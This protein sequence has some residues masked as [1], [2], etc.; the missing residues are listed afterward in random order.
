[1]R[2]KTVPSFFDR[3]DELRRQFEAQVGPSRN[4]EGTRFVWD[5]WHIPGQYTYLRTPA[6]GVVAPTLLAA[7]TEELRSWGKRNLGATRVT[8]PWLSYYIE[9]CRQELHTDVIQ[10]TWSY[11]Y[12]LT[13][14]DDR[15]FTGGETLLGDPR[16]L[17]YWDHFD[18]ERSSEARHLV[19]R[20]PARFDQLC[21][22]DSR[23]P[24][25]VG[26]VEGTRDPL[27]ARVAL[28]GWFHPAEPVSDGPL[29]LDD[30]EST[31]ADLQAQWAAE[32]TRVGPFYGESAWQLVVDQ[33]G[34][35]TDIDLLVDNLVPGR[36]GADPEELLAAAEAFI[37][38]S[39][40]PPSA[41]SSQVLLPLR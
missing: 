2:M 25:G 4:T 23:L 29:D 8:V 38:K 33:H 24:H 7:F 31:L 17:D 1:M 16:L 6:L 3:A 11:V 37:R 10:G 27:K 39:R 12:S 5:Y 21:V 28:H 20:V 40:F 22:F 15:E 30:A 34:R 35:V 13:S 19:E 32:N 41:G 18:P 36:R 9:G 26:I 14:W